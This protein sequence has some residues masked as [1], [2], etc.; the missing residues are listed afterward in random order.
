VARGQCDKNDAIRTVG[1]S[2]DLTDLSLFEDGA[3]CEVFAQLRSEA[4]VYR[5][6]SPSGAGFWALTRHADVQALG[7]DPFSFS[8]AK[9]G[10]MIFDQFVGE[11]ARACML[12]ELDPPE[13]TR[14][15]S[16]VKNGFSLETVSRLLPWRKPV[17]WRMK[18]PSGTGSEQGREI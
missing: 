16:L 4:P 1:Q 15:R 14:Y 12:L 13:H 11:S 17:C 2:I 6:E 7:R 18:L 8:V 9:R 10:N 3:P 5:N